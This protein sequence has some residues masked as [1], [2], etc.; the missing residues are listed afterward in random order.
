MFAAYKTRKIYRV[1]A[2]NREHY[3]YVC[4][5]KGV[6]MADYLRARRH[7]NAPPSIWINHGMKNKKYA[8]YQ[9]LQ[10]WRT[11]NR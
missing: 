9:F 6:F 11:R 10:K 1:G 3:R 4:E 7:I 2:L 5:K 8:R